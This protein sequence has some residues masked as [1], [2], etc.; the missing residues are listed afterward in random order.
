MRKC[1][2]IFFTSVKSA[3]IPFLCNF[4]TSKQGYSRQF[5]C[6]SP[7]RITNALLMAK[8]SESQKPCKYSAAKHC[9]KTP[10][11]TSIV[12][13]LHKVWHTTNM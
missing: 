4:W 7:V 8:I 2:K 12:R 5:G 13:Q 9:T 6:V 11:K 3:E 1:E 10:T